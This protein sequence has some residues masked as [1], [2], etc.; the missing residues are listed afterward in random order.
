[1]SYNPYVPYG[2]DTLTKE[3]QEVQS[4]YARFDLAEYAFYSSNNFTPC[5]MRVL[6]SS[7]QN[8]TPILLGTLAMLSYS[9]HRDK[10]PVVSLGMRGTKGFTKGHRT[11]AGSL[12]FQSI[13]TDAFVKM[14]RPLARMWGRNDSSYILADE[15]PP[16]DVIVTAINEEGGSSVFGL[17]GITLLDFGASFALDQLIPS[18]TYSFAAS[19][20][21]A[22]RPAYEK[23]EKS[24]GIQTTPIVRSAMQADKG[25]DSYGNFETIL[26]GKSKPLVTS[27]LTDMELFVK[28]K[29]NI[30]TP[31]S[32]L[33]DVGLLE[34]GVNPLTREDQILAYTRAS[35]TT[36]NTMVSV[37]AVISMLTSELQN[38]PAGKTIGDISQAIITQQLLLS[39]LTET[40]SRQIAKI[41]SITSQ[42]E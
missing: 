13:D 4:D 17:F 7:P 10:F 15:L 3:A 27:A 5:D 21:T 32:A 34:P 31:T 25:V 23:V 12:S 28:N 14:T 33:N 19:R 40:Y 35:Q 16:F 22:P 8:G 11:I 37:E 9:V 6:A 18:E 42:Q 30:D 26:F 24:L 38:P 2:Y 41:F 20:A 39:N 1:M 29:G 36:H